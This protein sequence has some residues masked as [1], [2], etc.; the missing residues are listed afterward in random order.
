MAFPKNRCIDSGGKD[1]GKSIEGSRNRIASPA[2]P[3][4]FLA[5]IGL[6]STDE[7]LPVRSS[8]D[9]MGIFVGLID[10]PH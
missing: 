4:E 10:T 6:V 1:L 5:A 7:D 2:I 9:A 8:R 3:T